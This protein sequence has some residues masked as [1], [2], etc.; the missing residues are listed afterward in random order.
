MRKDDKNALISYSLSN[1]M[2]SF[3][4]FVPQWWTTLWS[5]NFYSCL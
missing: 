5:I 4:F 3:V 1:F 2:D